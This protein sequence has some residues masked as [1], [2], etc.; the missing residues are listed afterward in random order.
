MITSIEELH[1]HLAAL[2]ASLH[3]SAIIIP[4]R[5]WDSEECDYTQKVWLI[6]GRDRTR[7]EDEEYGE[8]YLIGH[9]E[10]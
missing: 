10:D 5:K 4:A 2:G 6:A 3:E 8:D 9:G 1:K 7:Q